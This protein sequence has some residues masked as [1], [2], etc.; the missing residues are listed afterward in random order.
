MA[1]KTGISWTDSTLNLW[2]GC[3][4]VGP[5]CD[6][7]YAETF[8][9]RF[10]G[11]RWGP[12]APR[13][14]TSLSNWNQVYRW[15]RQAEASGIRR[16]VFI[17]SL[18]DFWDKEAPP[19]AREDGFE[20]IGRCS[21][22]DF[23]IV[24]KRIGNVEKMMPQTWRDGGWPPNVWQLISVVNQEEA[25][26]DIPKL[27]HL[28]ERHAQKMIAGL[29]SEPLLG[30]LNLESYISALDWVIVG[31]ESGS[32]ARP[33]HPRWVM[34]VHAQCVE[35]G[36]PF[37]FKQ[38]GEYL[39]EIIGCEQLNSIGNGPDHVKFHKVGKLAA[40]DKLSGRQWHE[41]PRAL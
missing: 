23:Q 4:K 8:D 41:F 24:T 32:K 35:H 9:K 16:K 29:C 30:P 20:L 15:N 36:V 5:G 11:N 38:W 34:D 22:L 13:H 40:G 7:C 14:R 31:G 33:M 27:I 26:R 17:N 28:K 10:G 39:P 2:I 12:G 3:T 18:S 25:D 6:H 1:E 21:W 19:S 37:F